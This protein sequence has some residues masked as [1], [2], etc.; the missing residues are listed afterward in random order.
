MRKY[1]GRLFS[2]FALTAP[3]PPTA[4]SR[5]PPV[6]GMSARR[7]SAPTRVIANV[8]STDIAAVSSSEFHGIRDQRSACRSSGPPA[9][10][11]SAIN[12]AAAPAG[13][14]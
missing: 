12:P 11:T 14:Q 8:A 6:A 1:A 5:A 3:S 4:K 10:Q 7:C 13:T 2:T 9:Q